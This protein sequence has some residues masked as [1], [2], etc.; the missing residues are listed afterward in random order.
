[1]NNR[2]IH[3]ELN[4]D[5]TERAAN[6]YAKTFG[7]KVIKWEG[8]QEYWLIA[9][10]AGDEKG[11]IDGAITKRMAHEANTINVINVQSLSETMAMVRENGGETIAESITV[12]GI[13]Y[14]TYCL[15]SEG[16]TFGLLQ[17]DSEAK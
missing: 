5:E 3:F 6:F 16:N 1:M 14:M 2:V 12:P 13:G 7:W 17:E 11:G 9:T 4:A 15:D 10:G 8:P